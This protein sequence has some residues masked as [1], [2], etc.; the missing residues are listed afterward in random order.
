MRSIAALTLSLFS[1]PV[2]S[3]GLVAVN[4]DLSP[5][6]EG[7]RIVVGA[8]DHDG[9][10]LPV[11]GVFHYPFGVDPLDPYFTDNPG[12]APRAGSGLPAGSQVRFDVLWRLARWGGGGAVGFLPPEDGA[13]LFI[14]FTPW[15]FGSTHVTVTGT[16]PA[17]PGFAFGTVSTSGSMHRH[18]NAYL[19]GADGNPFGGDGVEP[20]PGAYLTAIRLASSDA[21]I[22]PSNAVY[23]VYNSG[24][25]PTDFAGAVAYIADPIPGDADFSGRVDVADLGLLATHWQTTGREWFEGDFNRDGAVDV[26][27]LGLIASNWQGQTSFAEAWAGFASAIPE[28]STALGA[29]GLVL[30]RRRR[31]R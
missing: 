25:A 27:D 28:P 30:L 6:V 3:A 10:F 11:A 7:G 5:R 20:A 9:N 16:T 13:A 21:G 26:A 1:V 17:Q 4:A 23:L 31:G 24:L 14:S 12:V 29:A 8:S 2:A 19:L 15:G 22:A 18:L